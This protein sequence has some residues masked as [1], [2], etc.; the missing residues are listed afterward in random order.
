[1]APELKSAAALLTSTNVACAAIGASQGL[2]VLRLL[3]PESYGAA[4]VLVAL[5]AVATNLVDVRLTDLISKLYY[6]EGASFAANGTQYRTSVLR[7]GFGLYLLG[8]ALI[9]AVSLGLMVLGARRLTGIE[10]TTSWLW[11][12]AAAQGVSYL[13]SFFIF[14][15]RFIALPRRMAVLQLAS[16]VINAAAMVAFVSADRSVGGYAAGLMV[17]AAGIATLNAWQALAI[18]GREGIALFGRQR[19]AVP[20]IDRRTIL[21]FVAAGNV[22]GYVKLLHRAAD[23]LL[24]AALCGDRETGVYKLARVMTDSLYAVSEAIGR[25]YQPRLLSLLQA[26]DHGEYAA[27]ARSITTTAAALTVAAL[28]AAIVLL[29]R[30]APFLGADGRDL[31]LSVA[32]LTLAFFFVAGLQSWIWPAFVFFGRLGR[33][34]LWGAVAVLGGQYTLGPAL[35]YLT[36]HASPA[37]FSLGYLSYYVL[38]VLPLW[39]ELRS[40][41]P[42]L[43]WRAREVAAQ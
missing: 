41:K 36:G 40:D 22:L 6:D 42:M 18:L 9:T 38:S 19:A 33:C 11:M 32:I 30:L 3:G 27:V 16:A 39:R 2:L 17:S 7:L 8:A 10:L 23:V 26:R 4:A 29:P 35:V 12:A 21:R 31:T 1:M 34:T 37:W 28:G 20:V 14:I 25:V 13:G 15:Q 5:T 43:V 24:V